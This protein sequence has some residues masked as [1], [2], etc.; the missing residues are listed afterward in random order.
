MSMG[1]EPEKVDLKRAQK[2]GNLEGNFHE[3]FYILFILLEIL[4]LLALAMG[5]NQTNE[6]DV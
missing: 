6:K 2:K 3:I 4:S 5:F 1:K